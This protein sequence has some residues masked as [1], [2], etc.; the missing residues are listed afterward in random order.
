MKF[1]V[2]NHLLSGVFFATRL[3]PGP[4]RPSS[5]PF[6]LPR[7]VPNEPP[8]QSG[9]HVKRDVIVSELPA[10]DQARAGAVSAGLPKSFQEGTKSPCFDAEEVVDERLAFLSVP[11]EEESRST[12]LPGRAGTQS[13]GAGGFRLWPSLDHKKLFL[14]NLGPTRQSNHTSDQQNLDHL[15]LFGPV[16]VPCHELFSFGLLRPEHF[17][18]R[19]LNCSNLLL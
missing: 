10:E 14:I 18:N 13:N 17:Q 3:L 6:L 4:C 11:L 9:I 12:A 5:A 15:P 1:I 7:P 16:G 2:T 8:L 19:V